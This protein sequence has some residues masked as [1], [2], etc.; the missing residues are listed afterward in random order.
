MLK[1]VYTCLLFILSSC[2]SYSQSWEPTT[3]PP[4]F[5]TDHSYGFAIDGL[6]YLVAG[7]TEFDGPTDAF[8]Q[9]DPLSDVWTDLDSFPGAARGYGIGDVWDRKAY[10][11]FGVS[12]DSLLRDLWVFDP[13]SMKWSQLASCPCEPRL[14]PTFVANKGKIFVGLGNNNNGNLNDWWEYDI[15]TDQWSQKPDFPDTRRHHPYQFAIGDYVYTGL[16]HGNGIFREWYR[17]DPGLEE[18][19]RV[20]DI[21]GEGRVAGTQFSFGGKG[22]VLSGDGDDHSSMET[23]EFW[24]YDPV[25][26][27]W[28]QLPPHPG[29]SRWAPSSF[30]ID[31]VV[32]LFNG[33]A[34]IN[35]SGNVYQF[36]AYK[37]DLEALLSSSA[38]PK[39]NNTFGL[40]PNPTSSFVHLDLPPEE[41]DVIRIYTHTNQLLYQTRQK[42][43]VLDLSAFPPGLY[44]V[45]AAGTRSI[46][47]S[48][49][50]KE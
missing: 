19:L 46:K 6:G 42:D 23:G 49:M 15:S 29:P 11:G 28:A 21:P 26:D 44:R 9:Y 12:I 47:T 4:D 17:Y 33:T 24:S 37:F 13:D 1:P 3:A 16:G 50:V 39:R 14:H 45:E 2:F 40:Y 7:T 41:F 20:A 22:F 25:F 18:W 38:A 30:I 48:W 31:G 34:W 32:Y 27:T 5:L 35:G 10:F 36:E 8:M 43:R